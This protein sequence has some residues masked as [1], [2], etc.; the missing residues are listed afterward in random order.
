VSGSDDNTVRI[1][2]AASGDLEVELKGH[3]GWVT[4]V[5]FSPDGQH[6]VSGS[7]DNTV[8]IWSAASGDLEVELKGHTGWVTSVGF[9]P[10]GQHVVSGS[11]DN[12]VGTWK[13]VGLRGAPRID[14]AVVPLNQTTG[15]RI[16]DALSAHSNGRPKKAASR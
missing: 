11:A 12:T 15:I 1:W 9:S 6:V 5:G 10:D 8:R 2:S 4:S 14:F 3:T 7:D 16:Y 13:N